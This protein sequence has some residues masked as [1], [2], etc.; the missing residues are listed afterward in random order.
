[1]QSELIREDLLITLAK[2]YEEDPSEFV[3]L[4]KQTVDSCIAREAVAELRN[5]GYV[6]EQIRGVIRLTTAAIRSTKK[7]TFRHLEL[8]HAI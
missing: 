4:P 2:R 6:E 3:T 1:M 8:K 5:E 7:P